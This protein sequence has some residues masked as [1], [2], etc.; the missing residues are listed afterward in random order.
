MRCED[1]MASAPPAYLQGGPLLG[2]VS[3][4]EHVCGPRSAALCRERL[5]EQLQIGVCICHCPHEVCASAES[6]CLCEQQERLILGSGLIS[7]S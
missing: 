4:A 7:N 6:S 5:P 2:A 1:N 3:I